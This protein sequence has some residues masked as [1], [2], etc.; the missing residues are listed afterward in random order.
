VFDGFRSA[1]AANR[2]QF[3][4]DVPAGPFYGLNRDGANVQEGRC[5]ING[6]ACN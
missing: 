1:L 3:F 5:H 6:G 2:A 4:R